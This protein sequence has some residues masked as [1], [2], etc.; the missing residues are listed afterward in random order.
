MNYRDPVPVKL[1]VA[2]L[3]VLEALH[4]ILGLHALYDSL[5]LHFDEIL[6]IIQ[7]I[8]SL[9]ADELI[10]KATVAVSAFIVLCVHL[11]YARRIWLVCKKNLF[12]VIPVIGLSIAQFG[13]GVA[14]SVTMIRE[15]QTMTASDIVGPSMTSSLALSVAADVLIAGSLTY[16]LHN[17]RSGMKSSDHLINRLMI[18]AVNNGVLTSIVGVA[19]IALTAHGIH[20]LIFL[21]VYQVIGNREV[22]DHGLEGRQC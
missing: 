13:C 19:I 9:P 21:A 10:V 12:L 14:V 11:F 17:S 8:W 5:V 22:S 18:Y 3:F 1:L 4:S 6:S 2:F 15:S 16:H 7:F 20:D